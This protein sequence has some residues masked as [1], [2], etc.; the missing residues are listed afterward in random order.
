MNTDFYTYLWLHA[1]AFGLVLVRVSFLLAFIPVFGTIGPAPVRVAFALVLSLIFT[2]LVA[3]RVTISENLWDFVLRLVPEALLG[4]SLGLFPRFIF[5]GVQLGGQ[6]LGFQMGFGMANVLDPMTGIEAPV[7][8]QMA[9]LIALLLFLVLDI[10]HYFFL[11]MGE[12]LKAFPPGSLKLSPQLFLFLVREGDELFRLALRILA[13][14]MAI[15][16]L[17]Q[18]ALGIVS[19]FVPQINVMIVSFP[20]TIGLGLFFFGLTLELLGKVLTPA[21]GEAV[22]QLPYIL[23]VF[24]G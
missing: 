19:R 7:L 8:S 22:R 3:T 2:P 21:Y 10:H 20:L 12:G 24:G 11:A 9:Y 23:K 18:I 6:L 17:V 15:L 4:M 16:L 14:V 13:P 1:Q 5:A